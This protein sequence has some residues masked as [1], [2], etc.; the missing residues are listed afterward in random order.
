MEVLIMELGLGLSKL[1]FP[2]DNYEDATQRFGHDQ[3]T[4]AVQSSA[5]ANAQ[6]GFEGIFNG[7]TGWLGSPSNSSWHAVIYNNQHLILRLC[8]VEGGARWH[9]IRHLLVLIGFAWSHFS[10]APATCALIAQRVK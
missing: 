8:W 5:A 2:G 4:K 1:S 7:L 10:S 3:G 6:I 9:E